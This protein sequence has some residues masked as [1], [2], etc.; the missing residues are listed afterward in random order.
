[1][2]LATHRSKTNI[3]QNKIQFTDLFSISCS[4]Y[5]FYR[6][7]SSVT[8]TNQSQ[9]QYASS[10]CCVALHPPDQ[11]LHLIPARPTR[12]QLET[13]PPLHLPSQKHE[14][15]RR[16]QRW[17]LNLGLPRPTS[18]ANPSALNQDTLRLV[19]TLAFVSTTRRADAH[20]KAGN[21]SF[22]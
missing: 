20:D 10:H 2:D 15:N 1:M 16:M 13:T 5:V 11:T 12:H 6:S 9:R 4:F 18:D 22:L 7:E 19:S 14:R 3:I 21:R 8:G 17:C